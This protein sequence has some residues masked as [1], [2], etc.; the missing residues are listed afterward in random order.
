MP[1]PRIAKLCISL[2]LWTHNPV[3]NWRLKILTNAFK[4]LSSS[5]E[6]VIHSFCS[7]FWALGVVLEAHFRSEKNAEYFHQYTLRYTSQKSFTQ[8]STTTFSQSLPG[9]RKRSLIMY[10]MVTTYDRGSMMRKAPLVVL[11]YQSR[12]TTAPVAI[13]F[14]LART[15]WSWRSGE[16]EKNA[17]FLRS[18]KYQH[19]RAPNL[20]CF[21]ADKRS[22]LLHPANQNIQEIENEK[23]S[24]STFPNV[25]LRYIAFI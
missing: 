24:T 5:F 7:C 16:N 14:G 2:F 4:T 11:Q 6:T 10:Y 20:I 18:K 13:S 15:V 25:L 19:G 3:F 17:L 22:T 12:M 8:G 23:C 9:C 1:I 21:Q